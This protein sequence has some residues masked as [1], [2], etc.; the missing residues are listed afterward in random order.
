MTKV[1]KIKDVDLYAT[2]IEEMTQIEEDIE[3]LEAGRDDVLCDITILFNF[4]AHEKFNDEQ[5]IKILNNQLKEADFSIFGVPSTY[6]KMNEK[7]YIFSCFDNAR[8]IFSS[9][10]C[11][12]LPLPCTIV[13]EFAVFII[14]SISVTFLLATFPA[15]FRP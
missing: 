8:F 15:F 1:I 10:V 12:F 6:W 9:V 11:C 14:W 7:M 2:N 3:K 13:A 5:I 4:H